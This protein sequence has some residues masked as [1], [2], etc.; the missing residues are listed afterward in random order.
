MAIIPGWQPLTGF[1]DPLA[2]VASGKSCGFEAFFHLIQN[3]ITDLFIFSTLV[4]VFMLM[5]SGFQLFMA[6]GKPN[7][8][9]E[10]KATFGKVIWGYVWIIGAWLIVHSI[11]SALIN[12]DFNFLLDK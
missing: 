11:T 1:C 12:S 7:A 2:T 5:Y 9:S 3:G 10:T 8:L 4:V 6:Q